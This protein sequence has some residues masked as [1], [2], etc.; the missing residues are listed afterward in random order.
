MSEKTVDHAGKLLASLKLVPMADGEKYTIGARELWEQ[1]GKPNKRFANWIAGAIKRQDLKAG[2]DFALLHPKSAAKKRGGHNA[3][4]YLLTASSAKC[5]VASE[6]NDIG[7]AVLK[8]LIDL[9]ERID[10]GDPQLAAYIISRM[11]DP[12]DIAKVACKAQQR[13]WGYWQRQGKDWGWFEEWWKQRTTGVLLRVLFT[14]TLRDH[15]VSGA[16]YPRCTNAVYQGLTNKTAAQLRAEFGLGKSSTPRDAMDIHDLAALAFAE[17]LAARQIEA[18]NIQG[19]ERCARVCGDV[20]K[21]V[22]VL[23]DDTRK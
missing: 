18:R 8:A 14:D 3:K 13:A 1:L 20:A 6:S 21:K 15:G 11:D 10:K 17:S 23:H 19:N 22:K 2:K 16:G 5:I 12:E 4:D 9:E 7:R